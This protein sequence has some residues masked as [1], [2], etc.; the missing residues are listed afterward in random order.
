MQVLKYNLMYLLC[1]QGVAYV[2]FDLFTRLHGISILELIALTL[3]LGP[4]E[5]ESA[6]VT[7]RIPG[8]EALYASLPFS[9]IIALVM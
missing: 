8:F 4:N 9:D 7:P 3:V 6:S 2:L 1:Q 5:F